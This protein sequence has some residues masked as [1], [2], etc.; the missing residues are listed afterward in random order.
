MLHKF[1]YMLLVVID[2]TKK[3]VDVSK[4]WFVKMGLNSSKCKHRIWYMTQKTIWIYM[5]LIT[6]NFREFFIIY[7]KLRCVLYKSYSEIRND[8]FL[9][10]RTSTKMWC[11]WRRFLRKWYCHCY[12]C[13]CV[14]M[15]ETLIFISVYLAEI[16]F[17]ELK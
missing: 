9:S 2:V 7:Q 16:M 3:I 6:I 11:K 8:M 10:F 12:N 5:Q 13:C 1:D 14:W 17:L 15:W 4:C